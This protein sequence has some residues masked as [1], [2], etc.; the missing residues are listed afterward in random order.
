MD[1]T[2]IDLKDLDD[3]LCK[4]KVKDLQ[5]LE[6]R[7]KKPLMFEPPIK[8][9]KFEPA[10]NLFYPKL[11]KGTKVKVNRAFQGYCGVG[12]IQK[13]FPTGLIPYYEIHLITGNY[14]GF[15]APTTCYVNESDV[16]VVNEK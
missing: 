11:S 5:D 6:N 4:Y 2:T 1:K 13:G 7:L 3:L 15:P 12:I 16:E 8:E 9:T 14:G 10:P